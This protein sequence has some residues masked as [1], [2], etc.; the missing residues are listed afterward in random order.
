MKLYNEVI[1]ETAKELKDLTED[2]I[3]AKET[4]TYKLETIFL[5]KGL[6]DELIKVQKDILPTVQWFPKV[7]DC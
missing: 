2:A 5:E 1:K 3:K 6:V 4:A 7:K